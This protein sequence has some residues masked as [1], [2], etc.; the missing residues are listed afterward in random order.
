[1]I[2]SLISFIS[3]IKLLALKAFK[4]SCQLVVVWFV[5][6]QRFQEFSTHCKSHKNL[7]NN[8]KMGPSLTSTIFI[9]LAELLQTPIGLPNRLGENR[10]RHSRAYRQRFSC[11]AG[12]PRHIYSIWYGEPQFTAWQAQQR[13]RNN[14]RNQWLH[15]ILPQ[16]QT[17]LCSCRLIII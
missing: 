11:Y 16:C 10:Q 9:R 8:W 6:H 15:W 5:E 2:H 1:M 13:I 14:R 17:I 3:L 7:K 12:K 4:T